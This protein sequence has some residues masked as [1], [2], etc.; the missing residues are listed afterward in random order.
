MKRLDE[1]QPRM[2]SEVTAALQRLEQLRSEA[3]LRSRGTPIVVEVEVISMARN[4]DAPFRYWGRVRLHEPPR[5]RGK[6]VDGLLLSHKRD[7]TTLAGT[8]IQVATYSGVLDQQL[9]PMGP[10]SLNNLPAFAAEDREGRFR[11][12]EEGRSSPSLALSGRIVAYEADPENKSGYFI[13]DI[14]FF[15]D[16]ATV[17]IESPDRYRGTKLSVL[18][19]DSDRGLRA[20]WNKLGAEVK[21]STTETTVDWEPWGF[22]RAA[23]LKDV[24]FL[25]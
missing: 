20:A 18:V 11:Q 13:F 23:E 8:T 2:L 10:F 21:F 1:E 17:L 3:G 15:G 5:Y 25:R 7:L 16:M 12:Y 24:T 19:E 9:E 6:E 14:P 4:P 22:T